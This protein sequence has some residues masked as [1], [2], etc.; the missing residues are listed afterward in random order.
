MIAPRQEEEEKRRGGNRHYLEPVVDVQE[1]VSVHPRVLEHLVAERPPSPVCE[2][3]PLVRLRD[4]SRG[5]ANPC[6]AAGEGDHNPS[7]YPNRAE[8]PEIRL[9]HSETI[10]TFHTI[11]NH[12]LENRRKSITKKARKGITN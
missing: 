7:P 8:I 9:P 3:E 4:A 5:A 11:D 10:G 2:L 6:S 12:S 1:E